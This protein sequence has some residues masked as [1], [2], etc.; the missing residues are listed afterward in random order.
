LRNHDELDLGRLA[1]PERD[2]ICERLGI[3]PSM[4]IYN[5][6]IRRRLAPMLADARRV[7]LASS[8]LLSLTGTPV[9]FYGDELDMGDDLLLPGRQAVRTAMQWADQPGGRVFLGPFGYGWFPCGT[10]RPQH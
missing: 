6:A 9:L 5:H 7:K 1:Q 10:S 8:L 2:E 4:R 3:E